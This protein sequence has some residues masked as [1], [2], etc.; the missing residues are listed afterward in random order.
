MEPDFLL[1]PQNIDGLEVYSGDKPSGRPEIK[2]T[3][4]FM[5]QN[6]NGFLDPGEKAKIKLII[7]N[8]GDGPAVGLSL[9]IQTKYLMMELFP[10]FKVVRTILAGKSKELIIDL[11]AK[12]EL[13][14]ARNIIEVSATESYGY[15]P[16]PS[17]IQFETS[18][19]LLPELMLTDFGVETNNTGNAIIEGKPAIVQVRVQNRGLGLVE[20][21]SFDITLPKDVY[22][23]K[24]VKDR[25]IFLC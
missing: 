15:Y 19:F 23:Q 7:D 5:E 1:G 22:F 20:N 13:R 24:I 12:K 14:E 21:V 8:I 16:K 2:M 3:S 10:E 6:G 17:L 11:E 9:N 18:A 25:M 4:I